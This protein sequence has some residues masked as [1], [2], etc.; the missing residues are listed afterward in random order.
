MG[1]ICSLFKTLSSAAITGLR[2]FA[3]VNFGA[4]ESS[5]SVTDLGN[6]NGVR[7]DDRGHSLKPDPVLAPQAPR[8]SLHDI[9]CVFAQDVIH[10][11]LVV[12]T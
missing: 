9:A 7:G 8:S 6:Q 11:T 5:K 12:G 3:L 1:S 2:F 4:T 10:L